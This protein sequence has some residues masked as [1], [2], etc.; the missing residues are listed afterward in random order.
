MRYLNIP[1]YERLKR[2]EIPKK[3]KIKMIL[4]TDT[5]N[6]IDD[7]FAIFYALFSPE[8][9]E[10]K[11]IHAALFHNSRSDS[12]QDGMEKSYN[13]IC[14]I[15]KYAN[16]DQGL[17]YRGCAKP[18]SNMEEWE[19]SE[20]VDHTIACAMECTADDPLF[21]VGIGAA[22]NI[23]SA[24]LKKPEIMERI[25]VVWI[26][27]NTY[28]WPDQKEFNLGQDIMAGKILFDCGVPLIQVP[29]FGV[30]GFLLSSIPELEYCLEGVNEIGDYLVKNV[31]DY[32]HE[33]FSWGK[34]IW[35][36]GAISLLI[37]P[38]WSRR[39]I[40]HSPIITNNGRYSFS[41]NRHL[42]SC[43][44]EINRDETFS[45]MFLKIRAYGRSNEV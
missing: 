37:N 29:A 23:A 9:L 39:K 27:G 24:I 20:A 43:V 8:R 42:I 45:D 1:E 38:D 15:L 26:G 17:A 19:E 40:V 12:A 14:K 21:V 10:I 2:I 31:K 4:D 5:Y 44:S 32:P 11:G 13:E 35:D 22:T 16:K 34:P 6:E 33:T 3:R 7:Q 36:I 25:V 18:L 30:T 41:E 28:D